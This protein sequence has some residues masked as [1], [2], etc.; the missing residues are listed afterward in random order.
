[1]LGG[2]GGFLFSGTS[3]EKREG[4]GSSFGLSMYGLCCGNGGV[5][6]GGDGMLGEICEIRVFL[7]IRFEHWMNFVLNSVSWGFFSFLRTRK[8]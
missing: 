8:R 1:M 5:C 2:Y 3:G 4:G 7:G 6:F